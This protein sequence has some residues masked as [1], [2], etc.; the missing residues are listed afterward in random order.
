MKIKEKIILSVMIGSV[1]ATQ[2]L[3]ALNNDCQSLLDKVDSRIKESKKCETTECYRKA[4]D[5]LAKLEKELPACQENLEKENLELDKRIE[6]LHLEIQ[7]LGTKI[8]TKSMEIEVKEKEILLVQAEVHQ[9]SQEIQ[10][11]EIEIQNAKERTAELIKTLYYN[12]DN[13]GLIKLALSKEQLSDFFDELI[14]ITSLQESIQEIIEELKTNRKQLELAQGQKKEKEAELLESKRQLSVEYDILNYQKQQQNQ[15]LYFSAGSKGE[16][17]Q[18]IRELVQQQ[19]EVLQQIFEL[20]ERLSHVSFP[21]GTLGWPTDSGNRRITQRYGC[22]ECAS[23]SC[24]YPQGG[25]RPGYGFHNGLDIA[26]NPSGSSPEIFAA[27]DGTVYLTGNGTYFGKWVAVKHSSGLITLY[28]HLA[29][30][31]VSKGRRVVAGRATGYAN[32]KGLGY[33]GSTGWSTGNHLHFGVYY[34]NFGVT[35]TGDPFGSHTNPE[36]YLR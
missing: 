5:D 15:L 21:A 12:E 4:L 18:K 9:L 29:I 34:Q 16:N 27:D 2:A 17:E 10:Q 6:N 28:P 7:W 31:T 35:S 24:P 14:Y 32:G 1:I 30:I 20:E 22:V 26:P 23:W 3:A 11:K 33:M 13:Q 19:R 8:G 36:F 25:C